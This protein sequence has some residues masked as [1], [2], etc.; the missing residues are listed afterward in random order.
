MQR[1]KIIYDSDTPYN[2]KVVDADTG[3]LIHGITQVEL[4]LTLENA[5]AILHIHNP[6]LEIAAKDEE[7]RIVFPPPPSVDRRLMGK[8]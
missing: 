5:T 7:R 2:T 8:D 6:L 3:E 4:R 1:I